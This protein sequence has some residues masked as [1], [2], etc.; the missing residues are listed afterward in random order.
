[1]LVKLLLCT[2]LLGIYFTLSAQQNQPILSI[3]QDEHD[4]YDTDS[5]ASPAAI[6]VIGTPVTVRIFPNPAVNSLYID[7]DYFGEATITLLN[8]QGQRIFYQEHFVGKML[9]VRPY[10]AGMYW[11]HITLGQETFME[12]VI[13]GN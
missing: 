4:W 13:I 9:N 12:R 8:M 10:E 5:A 3:N 11:L 7:H 2:L 1:M 6:N